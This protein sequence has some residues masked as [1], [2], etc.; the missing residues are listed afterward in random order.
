[1]NY[2][3]YKTKEIVS[4]LYGKF[5]QSTERK[6]MNFKY[7]KPGKDGYYDEAGFLDDDC[8]DCINSESSKYSYH[9]TRLKGHTGEHAAHGIN[10]DQYCTW[11]NTNAQ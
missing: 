2:M 3:K 7:I 10:G 1:M 4:I 9:C 8:G 11:E 5:G 6:P